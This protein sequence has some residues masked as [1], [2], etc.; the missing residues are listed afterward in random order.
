MELG[1]GGGRNPGLS[2]A[3]NCYPRSIVSR[4]IFSFKLKIDKETDSFWLTV[5]ADG[6]VVIVV[7]ADAV[8][9]ATSVVSVSSPSAV[10]QTHKSNKFICHCL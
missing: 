2:N 5:D 10:K 4:R 3:D 6:T 8:V 9:G 7:P 1:A